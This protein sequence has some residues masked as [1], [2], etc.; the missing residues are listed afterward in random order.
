MKYIY[1]SFGRP[2]VKKQKKSR[3]IS[4][5]LMESY[6]SDSRNECPC[7]GTK[8]SL[9]LT[10]AAYDE[11][12]GFDVEDLIFKIDEELKVIPRKPKRS[13]KYVGT[14]D[15]GREIRCE[16][17]YKDSS[18]EEALQVVRKVVKHINPEFI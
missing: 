8:G 4:E 16:S 17:C 15:K 5:E 1:F 6:G 3:L 2:T 7:C 13:E 12:T 14:Y 10:V 9:V 18:F 11:K